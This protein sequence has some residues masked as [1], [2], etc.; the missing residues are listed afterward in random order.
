MPK[1]KSSSGPQPIAALEYL[2]NP[3]EFPARPVCVL[4]GDEPFLKS[5]S[6]AALRAAVLGGE[7]AE[8]SS[9]TFLGDDA[10]PRS[11]MDELAT[12]PLFGGGQRLV[13]V[14][15]ADSFISRNRQMLE[16]YAAQPKRTGVLLLEVDTWPSNTRLFKLL[17]ESGRQIDCREPETSAIL[18]WLRQRAKGQYGASFAPSAAE[19]LFEIVGPQMG[20]LDQELAKLSLLAAAP[21]GT[22]G[23]AKGQPITAELIE[24]AVGGWR[25]KTV[26]E[27]IDAAGDGNAA[28]ALA[29][30]DRLLAAGEN[31]I[32]ILAQMASPLR[33][34]A[35]AA[36][37]IRTAK[38]AGRRLNL[39]DAIKQT[40]PNVWPKAI[41]AAERQ[42][43]QLGSRR[44]GQ[45][46][47]WLLETDLA[48]KGTN[49]SP[50]RARLVLEQLIVRMS[51]QLA[52]PP[53]AGAATGATSALVPSRG[54]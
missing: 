4:F 8:F 12:V 25:A 29:Q 20:R 28:V 54:R 3:A 40:G 23:S 14:A 38:S 6:L 50:D 42:M 37:I 43:R 52:P 30:L 1:A 34:M 17:A 5:E 35:A 27:M 16:D 22:G 48:L 39:R 44:A 33:R 11:V 18:T 46:Y 19:R 31:P 32:G 36:R 2:A 49:S 47:H 41:D 45:I 9:R 15:E 26:W 51:R 13:V 10:D 21:G 7:E 53:P 24:Q